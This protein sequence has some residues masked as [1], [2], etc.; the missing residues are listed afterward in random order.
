MTSDH[1]AT[2]WIGRSPS[3][4]NGIKYTNGQVR[5]SADLIPPGSLYVAL[6]RSPIRRGVIKSIAVDAAL[7]VEGVVAVIDGRQIEAV[8]DP[9][10]PAFPFPPP[11]TGRPISG[12]CLTVEAVQYVGQAVAAVVAE[13]QH[14]AEAAA[15]RV[16]VDYEELD[17]VSN[18]REALLQSAAIVHDGWSSNIVGEDRIFAGDAQAAFSRADVIVEGEIEFKP[19]TAAPMEP[20]CFLASW[21]LQ[22]QHLTVTGTFQ[23]PHT[24]RWQISSALRLE[25]TDVRVI[26]PAMGGGFGFKMAGHPEEVMIAALSKMLRRPIAYVENRRDTFA[27]HCREQTHRFKIASTYDGCIT[28]FE[29]EYIA[30]VGVVGP[31]NGWTMPLVT[32]TVFPTVYDIANVAVRGTVVATNKAPWRPIRGYGKEIANLVMERAIDMLASRL[33]VDPIELRL[34]NVHHTE[35]LPRPLPSGL[36][37]DSGDYPAAITQLKSLFG[38]DEWSSRRDATRGSDLRVGIGIGIE[39]TPEGGARPGAFPSGFETASIRM[40]PTGIVELAIGVTSPGSGNETALAQIVADVLG[41][42]PGSVRIKQGDTDAVPV[43]TGNASSRAI[44]YGGPAA[45]LAAMDLRGKLA[46]CASN[47]LGANADEILFEN[48]FAIA[49]SGERV[50]LADLTFGAHTKPFTVAKGVQLPLE[51]TRSFQPSNVRVSPDANGRIAT[52]SSFPYSAHAVAIELDTGTGHVRV[53]DIATVHDCGVMINPALVTEQLKGAIVM[54]IGA[55]L[56]EEL[57][58]DEAGRITTDRFKSYLLPRATDLPPIKVGHM[59]TPSPF[60]PLGLKGAGESGLGGALAAVTNAVAD[61]LH[62]DASTKTI[63]PATP[64]RLLDLI[65]LARSV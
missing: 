40:S 55:G 61:A 3:R 25:E 35:A 42:T 6:V 51:A 18:G 13:S 53:L 29:D 45:H 41:L 59:S 31:C 36:N 11:Y 47:L 52:Y 19:S 54:G 57:K 60:H 14:A 44:L 24:S 64:P 12:R 37:V 33:G 49:P 17:G 58:T 50:S 63:V 1:T 10:P 43:G 2:S 56:W 32:G 9:T 7:A 16:V 15:D 30:D 34:R 38:Y 22:H 21:D 23:N 27:G 62:S 39:L 48:G 20:I 4:L 5:Y 46:L 8:T 26:A 65:P 28:A